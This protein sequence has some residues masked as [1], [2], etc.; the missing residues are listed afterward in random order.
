MKS[1]LERALTRRYYVPAPSIH[2]LIVVLINAIELFKYTGYYTF[3]R[4]LIYYN[5][6]I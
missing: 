3:T 6:S 4:I 1:L 2:Q 5:R